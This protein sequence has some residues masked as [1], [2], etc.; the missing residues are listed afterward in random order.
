M[1]KR[2][3][4]SLTANFVNQVSPERRLTRSHT[5]LESCRLAT[6]SVATH[7]RSI[8]T[9]PR[10]QPVRETSSLKEND[11]CH[12]DS[13]SDDPI[14]FLSPRKRFRREEETMAVATSSL[15]TARSNAS[16]ASIFDPVTPSKPSVKVL[17]SRTETFQPVTPNLS[18]KRARKADSVNET[19]NCTPPTLQLSTLDLD[20]AKQKDTTELPPTRTD[21]PSSPL[22]AIQSESLANQT[23][24][25]TPQGRLD[26]DI[27]KASSNC[28]L[29]RCILAQK[30]AILAALCR[31]PTLPPDDDSNS[32]PNDLVREQ[33]FN[34]LVG[35][36]ERGEGNSCLVIGPRSS[37]KSS[38]RPF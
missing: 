8:S 19:R 7:G 23:Q 16:G 2:K 20:I 25:Q 6:R 32:E 1:P 35:T 4:V 30:R 11:E 34:L 24:S 9:S 17:S 5:T 22:L 28:H 21:S 18:R 36:T 31:P 37:G 29:H 15:W 12:S 14:D 13:D 3:G 38:V 10:R 26:S 27:A 33:L